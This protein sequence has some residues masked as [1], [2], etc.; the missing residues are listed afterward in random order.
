MPRISFFLGIAIYMYYK[1]HTPPHFHAEYG[2]FEVT[3]E[4]ESGIV[5]GRF[6]RR[7]LN[8]VLEWS[9]LH[10]EELLKDWDL[11]SM[12]LPLNQIDPLE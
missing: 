6:P 5:S 2:D 7:A 9:M 8:I 11:A 10:K 1:E 12:K 3:I 4:I